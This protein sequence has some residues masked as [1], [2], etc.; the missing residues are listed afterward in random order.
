M[1][2]AIM[3][4]YLF[5]YIGYFQMIYSV[6]KFVFLDDVNFIKGGWINRN[7]ILINNKITL[8][9]LPLKNASPHKKIFEIEVV[10]NKFNEKFLKSITMA[11]KKAPYFLPAISLI[12]NILDKK[13]TTISNIAKTSIIE[14]SKYLSINTKMELSSTIYQN[15]QLRGEER[16][17]D[18]CK[19][20][21][22][23][24]YINLPGGIDIYDTIKF[25]NNNL[26]LKFIIPGDIVY[27]QFGE[28]FHSKLSIIDVLMFNSP[29][30]I[31]EILLPKFVFN[32]K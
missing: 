3:Q 8:F 31:K 5:P 7:N 25:K 22:C 11:Y 17:I 19:I 20:E 26:N 14:I 15:Q 24:D 1:K 12:Q 9:T 2:L 27:P 13:N 29:K 32:E 23:S 18:I 16:I 21:S 10:D 30:K 28:C 6:D 4:P